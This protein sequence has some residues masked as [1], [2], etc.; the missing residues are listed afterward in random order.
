MSQKLDIVVISEVLEQYVEFYN[1]AE[2]KKSVLDG[3]FLVTIIRLR[4]YHFLKNRRKTIYRSANQTFM[5][6]LLEM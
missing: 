2:G 3:V 5:V 6:S 1:T 4:F